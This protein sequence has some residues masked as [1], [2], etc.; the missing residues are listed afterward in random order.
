MQDYRSSEQSAPAPLT[1]ASRVGASLALFAA[2]LV[3]AV[4][5]Y[6]GW[7]SG[8][9]AT[10]YRFGMPLIW[11]ILALAAARTERFKGAYQALMSLFGVSLGFALAHVIG[12]RPLSMLG[13]SASTP[14]GAAAAKV[15]SEV[16]P[17]CAAILLAAVIGRRSLDSFALGRSRV[18]LSLGLGVLASV[19][20]LVYAWL[21]PAGDMARLLALPRPTV[22]SWL[23]WIVLFSVANG[24][25][26]E[27]WFRGSW[28]GA[29]TGWSARLRP[30]T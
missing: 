4:P 2:A 12:S 27:L 20:L 6:G 15:L 11:G 23:P 24:F 1:G 14:Q 13:L 25:M 29:F 3:T 5:V 10:A 8:G 9:L 19:P 16:I 22:L 18:W 21:D 26:E 17:V 30:C 28:F 7:L